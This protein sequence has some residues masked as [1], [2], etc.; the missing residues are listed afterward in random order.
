MDTISTA[1][2]T[3]EKIA[4]TASLG[5]ALAN[6][7]AAARAALAAARAFSTR[8]AAEADTRAAAD[9]DTDLASYAADNYAAAASYAASYAADAASYAG[10]ASYAA[11]YA[12]A[13]AAR[14]A[15]NARHAVGLVAAGLNILDLINND[16]AI[17]AKQAKLNHWTDSTPVPS[18]VFGELWPQGEPLWARAGKLEFSV[19]HI[20]LPSESTK[21]SL[22]SAQDNLSINLWIDPGTASA[23]TLERVLV[24]LSELHI[25]AG[26]T[27]LEYTSD[28]DLLHIREL[29]LA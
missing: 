18:S 1:I 3:A 15:A 21:L 16:Y 11:S 17:L 6:A 28:G 14:H 13:R 9:T 23:E 27:G 2:Q 7:A 5:D 20:Y 10:A 4:S 12:A 25:A 8:A 29:A 24:A 19:F 22:D 26:G